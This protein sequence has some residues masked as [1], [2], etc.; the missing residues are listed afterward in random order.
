MR[1]RD[2][3]PFPDPENT[4]AIVSG[5]GTQRSKPDSGTVPPVE[6]APEA[7]A[8]KFGAREPKRHESI[9]PPLTVPE[10]ALS[11]DAEAQARQLR[12]SATLEP[13]DEFPRNIA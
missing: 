12:R 1:K 3:K 11:K 2:P 4:R 13:V 10:R 8:M 9:T 7:K 5:F 6:P